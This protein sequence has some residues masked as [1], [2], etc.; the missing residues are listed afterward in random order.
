M[1]RVVNSSDY[2]PPNLQTVII[3]QMLSI[4]QEWCLVCT[5][6]RQFR[7]SV[8]ICVTYLRFL[9]VFQPHDSVHGP[10]NV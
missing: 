4:G 8:I 2:F 3:A 5:V 9:L 1:Y 7:I 6:H 10:A